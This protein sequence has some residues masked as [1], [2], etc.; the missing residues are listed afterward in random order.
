MNSGAECLNIVYYERLNRPYNKKA[1]KTFEY[2]C[3]NSTKLY[4]VDTFTHT[5]KLNA[6]IAEKFGDKIKCYF[7]FFFTLL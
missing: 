4:T 6:E 2:Q 3:C 7:F 1:S 5:Q